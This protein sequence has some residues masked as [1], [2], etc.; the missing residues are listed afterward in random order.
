VTLIRLIIPLLLAATV[1]VAATATHRKLPPRLA[2]ALLA[3]TIASLTI[4]VVPAL[5]LVALGWLTHQSIL[6]GALTWCRHALG[7]HGEIPAWIGV[8]AAVVLGVSA[9]RITSVVRSWRLFHRRGSNGYEVVA[10]DA[11]FA[12]T[13]PGAGGQTLVSA[14]LVDSLT[15]TELAVVLAHEQAH[16]EHRH[17]RYVLAADL[18]DAMMPLLRP[19]RRRLV[20]VLERWADEAAVSQ[21]DGDR[22]MVARTLARVAL[23]HD[24]VPTPAMGVAGL[25]V[26]GRVDALLNPPQGGRTAVW[27]SVMAAGVAAAA[28]AAALQL[29]HLFPLVIVLCGR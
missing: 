13:L 27:A 6:D 25:G 11:L 29:H 21:A 9:V 7:A 22:T 19:L 5:L 20:F 2:A 4:A 14:A 12:Y 26:V 17:D 8:P 24:T 1:G 18:A 16:A 28:T 15:P 10:S 3:L 23:A